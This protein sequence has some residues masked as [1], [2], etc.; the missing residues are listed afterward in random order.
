[1]GLVVVVCTLVAAVSQDRVPLWSLL[2]GTAALAGGY[3]FT[4]NEAP[5][6]LMDTS[7]SSATTLLFTVGFGFL[8]GSIV[9]PAGPAGTALRRTPGD[10]L[11]DHLDE[12]LE[13]AQ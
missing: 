2:L 7:I 3:E 5:S 10:L 1:V 6:Q 4:Y 8:A 9:A 12:I 13:P 11:T